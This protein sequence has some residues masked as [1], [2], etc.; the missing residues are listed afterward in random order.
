MI[1]V[2]ST[3]A[4]LS[5]DDIADMVAVLQATPESLAYCAALRKAV[6][7]HGDQQLLVLNPGTAMDAEL[8][9]QV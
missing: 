8:A 3:G 1:P 7:S 9:Q 5:A 6:K 2:C 4:G